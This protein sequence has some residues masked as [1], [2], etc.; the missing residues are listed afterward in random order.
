MPQVFDAIVLGVGGMGSAACFELARRGLKVLGLEQYPLVHEHG[1]SHGQTRIIRTAYYE[2][3]NYVP[4][5]RRAWVRWYELEQRVGRHLLTECPCLN[6]GPENSELIAGVQASAAEHRL[7]IKNMT[8]ADIARR[9][10]FRFPENYRGVLERQAGFLLVEECVRAHIDSA[11]SLGAEIRGEEPVREWKVDGR[12]VEVATDQDTYRAEKLVVTAGAWATKLLADLGVPLTIMRQVMLWINVS[13][14]PYMFRRDHFPIFIADAPGGPFYGLPA[15]DESGI[16]IARHY[17]APE[18]AS[19]DEVNWDATTEDVP[20]IRAFL[21]RFVLGAGGEVSN[22]QVCMYTLTPDKH[23]VIDLHPDYP[24]V[25]V[26]CGFSGHGFKFASVV[27]EILADLVERG[28][29]SHSIE[30]FSA[31]RFEPIRLQGAGKR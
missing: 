8:A 9:T 28:E 14:N 1:S 27:G 29:T 11:M 18:L 3:P 25:V 17:G 24:Q 13:A 2:H 12:G 10:P 5:L 30:M 7:S 16:K 20:V 21:D 23:F 4:L 6:I 31:K 26:A 19:P 15:I 22:G